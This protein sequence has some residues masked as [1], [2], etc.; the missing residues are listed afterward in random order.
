MEQSNLLLSLRVT[1]D[2]ALR[3]DGWKDVHRQKL[4]AAKNIIK[5]IVLTRSSR[6]LVILDL[7]NILIDREFQKDKTV[8]NITNATRIGNF[9]VWKRPHLDV[10]LGYL[11]K[12]FDVAV[13]SSVK[14]WNV[15]QLI[16]F[17]FND[18]KEQL[19]FVWSQENCEIVENPDPEANKPLFMKNLISVWEQFPQYDAG[20]TLL[21]D[22]NK[23]KTDNNPNICVLNPI[24]WTRDMEDDTELIDVHGIFHLSYK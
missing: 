20:N 8:D 17:I 22:D 4:L 6:K 24:K 19:K 14:K 3:I 21:I 1:L 12:Y 23:D 15:D 9:L 5:D 2:E 13:W 11:F 18:Y 10:F 16:P 7:N